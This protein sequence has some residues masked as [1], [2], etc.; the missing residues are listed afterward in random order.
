MSIIE[1]E[2]LKKYYGKARGVE[3][4][5]LSVEEGEFFGFI[6]PNGAGKST[7]IRSMLGLIRPD[8]GSVRLFG[9]DVQSDREKILRRIGYVPSENAFYPDMRVSEVLKLSAKLRGGDYTAEAE[10]LC[11]ELQLDAGKKAAELSYGNRKKLSV[12]C[13]LQ[14]KPE[15]LI[16]DEP[17]G[18][19]D[20]LMQKAFFKILRELND[21]GTT[22]FLSSHVLSEIQHNCKNTAVIKDGRVIA[23]G[24]TES[25]GQGNVKKVSYT[26]SLDLSS[27]EGVKN[28]LEAESGGSFFY[29]GEAGALISALN[30]GKIT[31]FSVNEPELE[32]IFLHYYEEA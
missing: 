30:N 6:G 15:L 10:R 18:G 11:H 4:V 24:S 21:S 9:M 2:A 23:C 17:T 3:D 16:L 19:L 14:H 32:E 28:L 1:I 31:D 26:G 20:P 29:N 12:I 13:A 25:L 5:S 27:L 7:T 8:S 22:V